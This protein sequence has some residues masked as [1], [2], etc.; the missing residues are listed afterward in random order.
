MDGISTALIYSPTTQTFMSKEDIL[1]RILMNN[2]IASVFANTTSLKENIKGIQLYNN[3]GMMIANTGLGTGNTV[4]NRPVRKTEYSGLLNL[5][6]GDRFTSYYSIAVP[7]YNLKNHIIEDNIGVCI[8]VMDVSN[9][10]KILRNSLIIK[11]SKLLLL[12]RHNK[13]FAS[14]GNVTYDTFNTAKWQQDKRYIVQTSTLPRT[15]WKLISV[16]P[17][18]DLLRDMD[19]IKRLNIAAYI[20]MI[21]ILCVF[22]FIFFI[23]ILKPVKELINFMNSYPKKNGESRFHVEYP[24]EIS[25]LGINLNQ[26]L[27]DIDSLSREIQLTQK[28][29]YEMEIAKKQMEITSYRNQINPHFLYNTLECIRAMALYHKVQEIADISASLSNIFRYSVKGNDFVT[30]ADEIAHVKEYAKIIEFRFM[31]RI[32]VQIETDD[33]VLS[34]RML[35][36]LLQPI[37]ENAVFHGLEKKIGQGMVLVEAKRSG[38]NQVKFVISDNGYGME[39]GQFKSLLCLLDRDKVQNSAENDSSQGIGIANIYRRIKLFYG[40]GAAMSIQSKLHAGTTVSITIPINGQGK[41]PEEKSQ[42]IGY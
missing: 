32:Q 27:D 4:L 30:I 7:V 22:L 6:D 39:E 19:V 16:I 42:C 14:E 11:N 24:N 13:I 23:R 34:E 35:K 10:S 21:G 37:V 31:K 2:D 5:P 20:V 33:D 26:M 25:E 28:R 12:D 17:K 15:G 9:F 3:Q 8:F 41:E 38:A 1:D 18:A 36:M 40:D 29:M